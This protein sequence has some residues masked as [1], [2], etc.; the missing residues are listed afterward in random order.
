MSHLDF[1]QSS[2]PP[3]LESDPPG[4]PVLER[5]Y[6][7]GAPWGVSPPTVSPPPQSA[8]SG[9]FNHP[10]IVSPLRE[11]RFQAMTSSTIP[12]VSEWAFAAQASEASVAIFP[13][14]HQSKPIIVVLDATSP[15]DISSMDPAH[16]RKSLSLRLSPAW[17]EHF[18]CME[19]C[20]I[21]EAGKLPQLGLGGDPGFTYKP[22]CKK[23]D[24]YPTHLRVKVNTTGLQRVRYW[25]QNKNRVDPPADHSGLSWSVRVELRAVWVSGGSWGLVALATDLLQKEVEAV[26]CP[27]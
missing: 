12:A 9:A 23:T 20:L 15:F 22:I 2:G 16:T 24:A 19:A 17:E 10:G 5:A 6:I 18:G 25:D 14:S 1:T 8:G 26:Q 4:Y 11:K 13:L 27:F 7:F 21:H 3:G